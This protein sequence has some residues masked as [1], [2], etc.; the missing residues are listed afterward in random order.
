MDDPKLK[1]QSTLDYWRGEFL[2][3]KMSSLPWWGSVILLEFQVI[4]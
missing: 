1:L 4:W 2:M 3:I